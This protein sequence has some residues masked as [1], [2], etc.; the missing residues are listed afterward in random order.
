MVRVAVCLSVSLSASIALCVVWVPRTALILNEKLQSSS[1]DE[2]VTSD[3]PKAKNTSY[4][5]GSK[6]NGRK[7]EGEVA[8]PLGALFSVPDR[9]SNLG[10][11]RVPSAGAD[12]RGTPDSP[13]SRSSG[14][15]S[16]GQAVDAS[17]V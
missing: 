2:S 4:K 16:A 14:S 1:A 17:K 11:L 15:N 7:G 12:R 8:V 3:G 9:A 10:L 13:R 6:P 5:S